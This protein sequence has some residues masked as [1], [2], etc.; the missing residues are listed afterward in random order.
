VVSEKP[1]KHV[2]SRQVLRALNAVLACVLIIAGPFSAEVVFEDSQLLQSLHDKLQKKLQELRE[3]QGFAGG[4]AAIVLPDGQT[5]ALATGFADA[6]GKTPMRPSDRMFSGS[7]GKTY[8]A[9]LMLKFV[10][11]G[12]ARLDQK[13]S[14]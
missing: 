5:L 3:T 13:A 12:K 8:V 9:A 7:I 1:T 11:D 6:E 14:D 2:S 10:E 4:T